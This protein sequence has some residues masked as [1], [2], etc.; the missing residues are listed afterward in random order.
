MNM[1]E[2]T[3]S[4]VSGT[5][6]QKPAWKWAAEKKQITE[7]YGSVSEENAAFEERY[8]QHLRD[9]D[10]EEAA[11]FVSRELAGIYTQLDGDRSLRAALCRKYL[12]DYYYRQRDFESCIDY[13]AEAIPVL[14]DHLS[15]R[16]LNTIRAMELETNA[17]FELHRD[18]EALEL[19]E[20]IVS[21][22]RD[23]FG[24]SDGETFL[25]E[26]NHALMLLEAERYEKAVPFLEDLDRREQETRFTDEYVPYF[27]FTCYLKLGMHDKQNAVMNRQLDLLETSG[28]SD[29]EKADRLADLFD[30][31]YEDS[32]FENALGIGMKLIPLLQ[33]LGSDGKKTLTHVLMSVALLHFNLGNAAQS[34]KYAEKAMKQA[35]KYYKYNYEQ[36]TD[37]QK[38]YD[39]IQTAKNGK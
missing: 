18:D 25:A 3:D 26:Q 12:A 21:A 17:L 4:T 37:F 31:L 33:N 39:L 10:K 28:A 38:A 13:A 36:M 23:V 32:Q 11:A 1:D 2:R 29:R 9:T 27:L 8:A 30:A 34:K 16:D 19:S 6:G 22:Y 5:T 7:K 35:R 24:P 15:D 20:R 14:A